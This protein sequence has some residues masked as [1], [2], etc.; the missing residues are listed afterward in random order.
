MSNDND[1]GVVGSEGHGAEN[2]ESSVLPRDYDCRYLSWEREGTPYRKQIY[3]EREF[4][5]EDI[6][7]FKFNEG[8]KLLGSED[9]QRQVMDAGRNPGL[10][11]RKLHAD[12]ITGDKVR[13]GIIDRNLA[14][15]EHPEFAGKIIAYHDVGCNKSP[16]VGSARAPAAVSLLVGETIGTAPGA[17]VYFAAVPYWKDDSEYT[18]EALRWIIE[19]NRELPD[20]EKIRVVSVPNWPPARNLL[21][22]NSMLQTAQEEGIL[23]LDCN[24]HNGWSCMIAL[25]SFDPCDRENVETC[26]SEFPDDARYFHRLRRWIHVPCGYRTVAEEYHK[27]EFSYSYSGKNGLSWSVPYVA[28]VL[29]QG[30]QIRPEL[31]RKEMLG[32][33]YKTCYVNAKG[34]RFVNPPAF[35]ESL[36]ENHQ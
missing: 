2:R 3:Q 16:D 11:I 10:G 31:S 33:L 24:Y 30:W 28:G 35:I 32:V 18:A 15:L 21:V 17:L 25:A 14:S 23:V 9:L 34:L 6:I 7:T 8:T 26:E 1:S 22:W 13:V 12:G 27:G 20:G 4:N 29:A 5:P 36:K 19:Q